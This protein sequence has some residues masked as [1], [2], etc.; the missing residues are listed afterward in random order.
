MRIFIYIWWYTKRQ[1]GEGIQ[2][3]I[4]TDWS[5]VLTS[6][7][8]RISNITTGWARQRGFIY[9]ISDFTDVYIGSDLDS[10]SWRKQMVCKIS[11][12]HRDFMRMSG[13]LYSG[14]IAGEYSSK[15]KV[16]I[17]SK[18]CLLKCFSVII[19]STF[20]GEKRSLILLN[21][22]LLTQSTY[23]GMDMDTVGHD[24]LSDKQLIE[25][26]QNRERER[27]R[28]RETARLRCPV[29]SRIWDSDHR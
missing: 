3:N 15:T 26:T 2:R 19:Y 17:R 8:R 13:S 29:D 1:G 5:W 10:S 22:H 14:I 25:M 9:F 4:S 23:F 20:L 6:F 16:L 27:D 28:E 21:S 11:N 18:Y 12:K 7:D 24:S